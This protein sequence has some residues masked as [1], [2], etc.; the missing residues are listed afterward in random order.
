MR[1]L[2]VV[3]P[4][5]NISIGYGANPFVSLTIDYIHNLN[6]WI[7]RSNFKMVVSQER[8]G[9]MTWNKRNV[10]QLDAGPAV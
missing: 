9:Y 7:S 2:I 1:G 10:S 6:I 5:G 8:E 3:K 4:K